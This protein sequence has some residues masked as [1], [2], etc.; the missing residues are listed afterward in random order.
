MSLILSQLRRFRVRN[1]LIFDNDF[2]PESEMLAQNER[3]SEVMEP[4]PWLM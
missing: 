1:K 4:R 3:L 2:I